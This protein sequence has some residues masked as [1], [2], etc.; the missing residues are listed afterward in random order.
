MIDYYLEIIFFGIYYI[1]MKKE[2]NYGDYYYTDRDSGFAYLLAVLVPLFF[3][4]IATIVL[5]VIASKNGTTLAELLKLDYVALIYYFLSGLTLFALFFFYNKIVHKNATACAKINFKFGVRNLIIVIMLAFIVLLGLNQFVNLFAY[6]VSLA[7]YNP[8]TSM[9][10]PLNTPLWLILNLLVLAVIP[11]IS[12]ELIYRGI[13][14]NGLR[15]FGSAVA[16]FVSA[17]IFTIAHGSLMQFLYQF[18]LGVVL[19]YVVVKTGS[20][21]A[22]II[23]HFLNN[24]TVIVVN[25]ISNVTDLN[26][27]E[28]STWSTFDVLYAIIIAIFA[29]GLIAISISTLES[30]KEEKIY[31]KTNERIDTLALTLLLIAGGISLIIWCV[32]TFL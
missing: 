31:V 26:L 11:A 10:L 9:P 8:D 4:L 12:E 19:G 2:F 24:A 29:C 15:K 21:V 17:I 5:T 7:G 27:A 23:L 20:V 28:S 25:Y 32:G 16:V 13:I 14:L 3:Q 1:N 30:K 18:A 6:V 22:S